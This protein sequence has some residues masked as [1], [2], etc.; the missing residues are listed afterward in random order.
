MR[1]TKA[2]REYVEE[3]IYKKYNDAADNIGTEYEKEKEDVLN[4]VLE[5]IKEA[6]KE[7]IAYVESRGFKHRPGY[8]EDTAISLTGSI[9]K[10]DIEDDIWKKK[11]ELRNKGMAKAKQVLFDL[12]MGDTEKK[13]LKEV[14]DSIVVE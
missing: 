11:Q 1:V 2:I 6:N 7:V 13:Q 5:I 9:G 4:H 14:L 12:E 3:E 10:K 8:R